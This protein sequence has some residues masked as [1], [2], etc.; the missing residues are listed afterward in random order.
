MSLVAS[1][2]GAIVAVLIGVGGIV[3]GW[4]PSAD[5]LGLIFAGLS[6]LGV[7]YNLTPSA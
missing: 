4:F 6:I 5:G 1:I 3:L 7:H 2:I